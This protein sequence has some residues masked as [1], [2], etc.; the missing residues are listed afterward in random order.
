MMI[1]IIINI[2]YIKC[3][4]NTLLVEREREKIKLNNCKFFS[5]DDDK[6]KRDYLIVLYYVSTPSP[7]LLVLYYID[8]KFNCYI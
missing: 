7:I 8:K 5:D 4:Q 1:I 2:T 3:E 6:N